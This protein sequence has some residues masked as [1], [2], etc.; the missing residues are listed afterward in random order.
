MAHV[1]GENKSFILD[2]VHGE[3]GINSPRSKTR[4]LKDTV[5]ENYPRTQKEE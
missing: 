5:G 4:R 2:K 1:Q 3:S